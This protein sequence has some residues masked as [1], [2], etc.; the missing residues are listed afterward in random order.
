MADAGDSKSPGG[1]PVRV[2]LSPRALCEERRRAVHRGR[3]FFVTTPV[4]PRWDPSAKGS[5]LG[6]P[7]VEVALVDDVVAVNHAP[8]LPAAELP[9]GAFVHARAP[10]IARGTAPQT[11]PAPPRRPKLT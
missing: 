1:N 9:D 2:R 11:P 7:R 3:L 8:R 5:Q 4:G 10:E 6:D